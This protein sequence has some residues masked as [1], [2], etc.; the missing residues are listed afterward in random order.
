[1]STKSIDRS[2]IRHSIAQIQLLVPKQRKKL[3]WEALEVELIG[4][5]K[6]REGSSLRGSDF[7]FK[8]KVN[9][10]GML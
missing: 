2:K 9:I 8:S 3:Q 5:K 6:S 1:M 10:L 4:R 7:V